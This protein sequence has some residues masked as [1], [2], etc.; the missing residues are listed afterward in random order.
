MSELA[1]QIDDLLSPYDG[2]TIECDGFTRIATYLLKQAGIRHRAF[3]GHVIYQPDNGPALG[4]NPH[5][6]IEIEQEDDVA[7]I[8]DYRLRMWVGKDAPHGVF[9]VLQDNVDYIGEPI[10]LHVPKFIFDI[11]SN[12]Y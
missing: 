3:A 4:V 9:S 1:K 2:A 7:I 10:E 6:W 5:F 8:V 12:S 11:L